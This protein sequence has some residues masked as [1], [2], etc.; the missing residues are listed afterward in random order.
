MLVR[1]AITAAYREADIVTLGNEPT[2]EEFEEALSRLNDFRRSLFGTELGENLEDWPVPNTNGI[3]DALVSPNISTTWYL[4]PRT[5]SR[6]LAKLTSAITIKFPENP[7]D[8]SRV[9]FVDVGS[10]SVDVT[11]DGNGRLIEGQSALIDT[12]QTFSGKLWFYR[13]DL[14]SWEAVDDL[15][16]GD[17]LPL[18][19]EY[20]DLFIC[21]LA[22]RMSPRN[23]QTASDDTKRLYAMLVARAKARYR[24]TKATAIADPRASEG[25]DSFGR[26]SWFV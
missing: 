20:N 6:L 17:S 18:P 26:G 21:Y 19:A 16:L 1:D 25:L 5:N 24:Q 2:D 12:P 4:A 3:P 22:I 13:A 8:G 14:A 9:A 10:S 23:A 15:A 11:L 7:T